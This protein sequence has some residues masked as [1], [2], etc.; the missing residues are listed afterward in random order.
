MKI[1]RKIVIFLSIIFSYTLCSC[2]PY[3]TKN[4]TDYPNSTWKS[5]IDSILSIEVYINSSLELSSKITYNNKT[6]NF[7]NYI[8]SEVIYFTTLDNTQSFT[9]FHNYVIDDSYIECSFKKED[10]GSLFI[11]EE[12]IEIIS[13]ILTKQ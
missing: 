8:V 6:I 13:F 5:D 12:E 9:V 7:T 11:I 3:E 10:I 2:E 1:L 4:I